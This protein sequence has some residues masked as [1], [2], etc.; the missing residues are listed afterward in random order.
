MGYEERL[1]GNKKGKK[2]M[3]AIYRMKIDYGRAGTLFGLFVSTPEKVQEALSHTLYFGE[4]LGKHS[5][6]Y[7]KLNEEEVQMIT[8]DP[9]AVAI[10]LQYDLETGYNPVKQYQQN[11]EEGY[12]EE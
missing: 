6:I 5:D 10:F 11:I 3:S 7:G 1:S 2:D 4:L 9:V 8:D 12:Y